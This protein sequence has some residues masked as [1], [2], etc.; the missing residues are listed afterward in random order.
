MGQR[1]MR[2][3]SRIREAGVPLEIPERKELAARLDTV[4]DA[5]Y[6]VFAEGWTGRCAG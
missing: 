1:L 4:P 3:K 6:A 2:A 5:I